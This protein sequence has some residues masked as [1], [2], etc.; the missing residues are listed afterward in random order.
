MSPEQLRGEHASARSDIFSFGVLLYE[1]LPGRL[2]FS[3]ETSIDVLHAI[4]RAPHPPLRSL[5]PEISL[6]WEKLIDRCLA[7][8]VEE[9][10]ASMEEVLDALSRVG[11]PAQQPKKSVAFLYF[12]NLSDRRCHH[13]TCQD[14]GPSPVSALHSRR[15]VTQN[16]DRR[17]R[18]K[19]PA[20]GMQGDVATPDSL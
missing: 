2:P 1:C 6:E 11:A 9:R 5:L 7:K 13:R 19:D 20:V 4:L 14:Q 16:S 3:G 18:A 15:S 17:N 12:E 8:S 10:C